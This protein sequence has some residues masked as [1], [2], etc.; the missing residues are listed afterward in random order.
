MKYQALQH[1]KTRIKV[2]GIYDTIQEAR[3]KIESMGAVY[4]ERSYIGNFPTFSRATPYAYFSIQ[5]IS[6]VHGI[7]CSLS[8]DDLKAFA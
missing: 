4:Y 8:T 6:G 7:I 1:L 3:T 2:L 5:G